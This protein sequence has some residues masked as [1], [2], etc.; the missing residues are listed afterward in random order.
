MWPG[1]VVH[2]LSH[3]VGCLITLTKVRRV[4]LFSPRIA[5]DRIILGQVSHEYTRNPFKKVIISL[6]PF[7][8]VSFF[9]LI[10]IK[11][12]LPA[13]YGQQISGFKLNLN[14]LSLTET[15][16][17]GLDYLR[18]YFYYYG[19]LWQNFDFSSWPSYLFIY[20]MLS[21]GSQIAPSRADLKYTFEGL[22]FL[23]IIFI[24]LYFIFKWLKLGLV[25]QILIYL[26]YPIYLINSLLGYGIVF[27]L[28]MLVMVLLIGGI[29]S[30]IHRF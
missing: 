24:G 7:F 10:I 2:E 19:S 1:V 21:L 18:Q 15:L 8:G 28:L 14:G 22:G 11:L 4:E 25:W 17:F 23:F 29:R 27:V 12:L 16:D 5:G 6:A 9:I 26:G 30:L 20:L 3:F 13:L